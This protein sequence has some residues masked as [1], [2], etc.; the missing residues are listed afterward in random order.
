MRLLCR[1]QNILLNTIEGNSGKHKED[2]QDGAIVHLTE[3]GMQKHKVPDDHVMLHMHTPEFQ[4]RRTFFLSRTKFQTR[5][6]IF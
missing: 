4:R 3:D 5:G 1:E 6:A 2:M